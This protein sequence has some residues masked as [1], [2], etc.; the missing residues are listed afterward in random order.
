LAAAV[1]QTALEY[2]DL[3]P[4]RSALD[5]GC[6]TGML[7]LACDLV[8]C[9]WVV[10]VDCDEDALDVA[11]ANQER[12]EL[13]ESVIVWVRAHVRPPSGNAKLSTH[14]QPGRQQPRVRV[15][16]RDRSGNSR[17]KGGRSGGR[18][19]QKHTSRISSDQV[20][21]PDGDNNNNDDDVGDG[22][23]LKAR[24]VDTVVTNPPFGTK[25]NA[26]MDIRFLQTAA[27]LASR[28]VY[29]F[30]KTS[31]RD[32]VLQQIASW[33]HEGH[34][35]AQMKFDLPQTYAFHKE[36]SRDIDVDL[37]RVV[38]RGSN[39]GEELGGEKDV[40]RETDCYVDDND[41]SAEG[42]SDGE[43]SDEYGG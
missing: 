21:S 19:Q 12:L 7:T 38:I 42:S 43:V 35:V 18:N 8:E 16:G 14:W 9:D 11:R 33:G 36:K 4:G 2:D 28:A 22:F 39:E 5:L 34:V 32:Y 13:D 15:G 23:P 31:T 26:G 6:G 24:S 37:V 40:S 20:A 41:E 27:H 30:H 17:G 29:S 25:Q 10:G 1:I 3:G